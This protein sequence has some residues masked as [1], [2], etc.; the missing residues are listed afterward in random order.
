MRAQIHDGGPGPDAATSAAYRISGP[1]PAL[2]HEDPLFLGLCAAFDE[3]LSPV[4]TALDCFAAYLDPWLAPDDFVAWLAALVGADADPGSPA[5]PEPR[6]RALVAGAVR[7][8]RA[9]GTAAGLRDA[10]A[11]AAGVPAG[12]VTVAESGGVT[13]SAAAGT[14]TPPADP[15]VTITVVVPDGQDRD[16]IAACARAAAETAL[17]VFAQLRIETVRQ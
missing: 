16:A 7:S 13:W 6:R 1:V 14:A 17:P 5:Q 11:A 9:R 8:Y 12:R 4:V 2:F 15:V 3:L 10:V